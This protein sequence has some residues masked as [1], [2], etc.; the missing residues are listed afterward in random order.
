MASS[1]ETLQPA[2][3]PESSN[4]PP[5]V[6]GRRP[7]LLGALACPACRGALRHETERL[8]CQSCGAAYGFIEGVPRL[9]TADR[10]GELDAR[11][12]NF[13]NPHERVRQNRFARA[14]IPPN[15]ICDPGASARAARVR[16]LLSKGLVLNLGSKSSEWGS[17]VVNLD[18]MLPDE[19]RAGSPRIDVL[20]DIERLPFPDAKVDGIVCTNVLEH[21]G[22]AQACIAEISRVM[23]PGGFVFIST[24]FMFPTHPDPLDRRRWTLEGLCAAFPGFEIK[25][26][27]VCGGPFSAYVSIVP[28]LIGSMFSSFFLYNAVRF[29]LG[30]LL[31]PV[32]FLDCIAARSTHADRTAAGVYIIA[33]RQG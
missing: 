5:T 17:H 8:T 3:R 29:A 4:A 31:W 32:K 18:L 23:R 10:A 19:H 22:D 14:L 15:P 6:L 21:V 27:G 2:Q 16:E 20:A 33:R 9:L 12:A 26:S 28:T 1:V 13:K 30:W 24:P 7:E 11:I 25:E